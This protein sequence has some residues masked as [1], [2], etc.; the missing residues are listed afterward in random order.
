[1]SSQEEDISSSRGCAVDKSGLLRKKMFK[2]F[3]PDVCNEEDN[4]KMLLS[5]LW[6]AD[7]VT[8]SAT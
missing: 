8:R 6:H 4:G 7:M 3:C 2:A 1:M 5:D